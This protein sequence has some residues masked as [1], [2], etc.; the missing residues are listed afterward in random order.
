MSGYQHIEGPP[1]KGYGLEDGEKL[2]VLNF[3][4]QFIKVMTQVGLADPAKRYMKATQT[5]WPSF[6]PISIILSPFWQNLG[7]DGNHPLK[8]SQFQRFLDVHRQCNRGEGQH[9][10]NHCQKNMLLINPAAAIR[11][12][13]IEIFSKV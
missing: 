10:K 6:L 11:V 12:I 7:E 8:S 4:P 1:P 13:G 2:Q 3:M 5:Q 9:M